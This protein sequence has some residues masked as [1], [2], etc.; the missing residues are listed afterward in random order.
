M[1]TELFDTEVFKVGIGLDKLQNYIPHDLDPGKVLEC[2]FTLDKP[3]VGSSLTGFDYS[4]L[5]TEFIAKL[6][7]K[8]KLTAITAE[9]GAGKSFLLI[10]ASLCITKGIP[11]IFEDDE[12]LNTNGRVLLVETEGRIK[13]YV[14]RIIGLGGDIE[15]NN[16]LTPSKHLDIMSFAREDD[17]QLIENVIKLNKV[18]LVIVDSL[19]CFNSVDENSAAV[20]PCLSWLCN[21][22]QQYNCAVV[23][24]Q[25]VNKSETRDGRSIRGHSMIGQIP[26]LIY[27]LDVP[28]TADKNTKRLYQIKNNIDEIDD[29][30]YYF[31]L[32]KI[33]DDT[34]EIQIIDNDS[35]EN[36]SKK[37][38][39][40]QILLSHID[41]SN[42]EIAA[43]IQEF[44]PESKL[45][46]IEMWVGRQKRNK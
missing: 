33:D 2:D 5:K 9:A 8:G 35:K 19:A 21:L 1:Q 37:D 7:P 24:T 46:T 13:T 42:V 17:R 43:L 16:Y 39:R 3:V 23:F 20:A 22:A 36:K 29:K 30:E 41:K 18:D 25:L 11:F 26:E 6:F 32:A 40:K 14:K 27:A 15:R 4:M 12:Y 34:S 38:I 45:K 31:K 10:A 28:N 44:E